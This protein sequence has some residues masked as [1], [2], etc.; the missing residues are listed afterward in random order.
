M[1]LELQEDHELSSEES[2][3]GSD[4]EDTGQVS[5]GSL[6]FPRVFVCV[7]VE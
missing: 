2:D 4:D 7:G 3:S 5:F 6:F 1:Q